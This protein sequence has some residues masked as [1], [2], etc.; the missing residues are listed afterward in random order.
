MR[1]SWFFL[2]FIFLFSFLFF[3]LTFHFLLHY[4]SSVIFSSCN[5]SFSPFLPFFLCIFFILY[6]TFCF[7]SFIF[8]SF[9]L[10]LDI[11]LFLPSIFFLWLFFCSSLSTFL[12][13]RL[14][15]FLSFFTNSFSLFLWVLFF[16]VFFLSFSIYYLFR[17]FF[18][19]QF[20]PLSSILVS[21]SPFFFQ[22]SPDKH[23]PWHNAR[24]CSVSRASSLILTYDLIEA[25]VCDVFPPFGH[26][27]RKLSVGVANTV[28][29]ILLKK[30][31]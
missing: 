2:L 30:G 10:S 28:T 4:S 1:W 21:Y 11:A 24:F 27:S 19:L 9:F 8:V 31:K 12:S 7:G 22:L 26:M 5:I 25:A 17:C 23:M 16:I 15:F 29:Q 20:R 3:F 18:H 13:F 6:I 14:S